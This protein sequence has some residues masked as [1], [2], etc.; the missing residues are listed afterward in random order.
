MLLYPP[1]PDRPE[2]GREIDGAKDV[3]GV[4]YLPLP[5]GSTSGVGG[6]EYV[7]CWCEDGKSADWDCICR[8]VG[9]CA[10]SVPPIVSSW[11]WLSARGSYPSDSILSAAS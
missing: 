2:F 10:S 1:L 8:L 4:G 5:V 3:G 6:P 9:V 7:C 11:P